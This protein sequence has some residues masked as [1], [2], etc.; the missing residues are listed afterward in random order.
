MVLLVNPWH[1]CNHV[2]MESHLKV[3]NFL[4]D[5]TVGMFHRFSQ[6]LHV[7]DVC[8]NYVF[9]KIHIIRE[10][11][12]CKI[13]FFNQILKHTRK[14]FKQVYKKKKPLIPLL[15]QETP[16]AICSSIYLK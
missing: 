2:H 6:N 13:H 12:D 15:A 11:R 8:G 7:H 14:N 4:I 3:I 5:V 1:I 10:S 9:I 16:F